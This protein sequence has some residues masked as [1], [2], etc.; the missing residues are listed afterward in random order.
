[1]ARPPFPRPRPARRSP[2]PADG[3]RAGHVGSSIADKATVTGGGNPTGTVT[4]NLYNNS[5]G[6]GPARFTDTATPQSAAM[7]TS[8]EAT[9]TATATGTDYWVATYNGDSHQ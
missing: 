1:M 6:T 5:S 9:M 7:A 2:P 4:F 8:T 3:R